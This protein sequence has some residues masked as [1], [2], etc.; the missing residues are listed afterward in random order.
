M[1]LKEYKCPICSGSGK[2]E[3]PKSTDWNGQAVICLYKN[4]FGI[5]QIQRLLKYKSPAS[6][7]YYLKKYDSLHLH[8]NRKL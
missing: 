3:F 4:G 8:D 2:I 6:V 1:Q 5:R 7:Q